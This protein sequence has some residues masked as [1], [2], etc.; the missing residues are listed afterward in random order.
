MNVHHFDFLLKNQ[1]MNLRVVFMFPSRLWFVPNI[2][3]IYYIKTRQDLNV[4]DFSSRPPIHHHRVL[5]CV[6]VLLNVQVR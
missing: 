1:S 6:D 5:Q 3:P 4:M 2:S